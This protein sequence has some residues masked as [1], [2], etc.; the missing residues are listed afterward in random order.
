MKY[1]L[2]TASPRMRFMV[3]GD[4]EDSVEGFFLRKS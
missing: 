2:F 4:T 1:T 3:I